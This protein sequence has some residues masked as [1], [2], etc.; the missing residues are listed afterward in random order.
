M[1]VDTMSQDEDRQC[2]HIE[3]SGPLFPG[4]RF[5]G[6]SLGRCQHTKLP[7]FV[8]CFEHVTKDALA[9]RIRWLEREVAEL[10]A[11][12]TKLE[13]DGRG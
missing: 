4:H 9:L 5:G 7:S 2:T 8:Y 10:R 11:K 1:V 13:G 3:R 6:A 12:N